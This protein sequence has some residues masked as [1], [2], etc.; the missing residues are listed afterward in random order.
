VGDR[1]VHVVHPEVDL[2]EALRHA[3]Y[4]DELEHTGPVQAT[5]MFDWSA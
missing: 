4:L 3:G 1:F 2:A 5:R